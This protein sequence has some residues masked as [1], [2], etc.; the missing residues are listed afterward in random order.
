MKLPLLALFALTATQALAASDWQEVL[1]PD[2]RSVQVDV[3]SI[4]TKGAL[5]RF[6]WKQIA[7]E[8]VA[9]LG[10]NN[11]PYQFLST[12]SEVDCQLKT[13][14]HREQVRFN[15]TGPF[16]YTPLDT[17]NPPEPIA[18]G[19]T[20]GQALAGFVCTHLPPPEAAEP[21]PA[22]E[23]ETPAAH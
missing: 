22:G 18:A 1:A 7:P 8:P 21:A 11:T 4:R 17:T 14:R 5:A 23:A 9:A 12:L 6:W 13:L 20:L 15:R 3:S 19:D 16:I 2:G 10:L